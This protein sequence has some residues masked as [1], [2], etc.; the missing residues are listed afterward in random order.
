MSALLSDLA[1]HQ[2]IGNTTPFVLGRMDCS[3]WAADWVLRQTGIDLAAS[4]RGAYGTEREYMR[5]LLAEGGLVRVAVRAMTRLGASRVAPADARAGDVG[6]IVT[7]RG[8]ALAIR[9]QLAWMAKTGDQLSTTP[10]ASFAWR[11]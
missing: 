5:L 1:I 2:R 6:I 9:G 11:I 3:L 4:W 8:P 10:A 7:E